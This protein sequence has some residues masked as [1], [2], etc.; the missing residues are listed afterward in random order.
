MSDDDSKVKSESVE[1]TTNKLDELDYEEELDTD[2]KYAQ[3]ANSNTKPQAAEGESDD[4]AVTDSDG[5]VKSEKNNDDDDDDGE[6]KS[7][8]DGDSEFKEQQEPA[9]PETEEDG[10]I[11]DGEKTKKA[12]IPR[13]L[14]KYYQRGKCTWGRTCKFLHPGVNDT[15]NYS[16]LEFQDPNAKVYQQQSNPTEAVDKPAEVS[17]ENGQEAVVTESAWERG[18]RHA[19]EMKE[20]AKLRKLA[21]KDQFDDKKMNLSLKEFENEKENDERYFSVVQVSNA[22]DEEDEDL[23]LFAQ[24]SRSGKSSNRVQQPTR[25]AGGGS[26][27]RGY[28][29][30]SRR[31]STSDY[32]KARQQTN[33]YGRGG[34][35]ARREVSSP[36]RGA[37]RGKAD[38]WHD[39][40]DRSRQSRREAASRRERSRSYSSSESGSRSPGRSGSRSSYS[41]SSSKS[42]SSKSS[43][44]SRSG[45]RSPS[46]RRKSGGGQRGDKKPN[47][48]Q[49]SNDLKKKIESLKS[50]VGGKSLPGR[51]ISDISLKKAGLDT[52]KSNKKNKKTRSR[53]RSN[54]SM[55]SYGSSE[56]V[57]D[58]EDMSEDSDSYSDDNEKTGK[59]NSPANKKSLKQGSKGG[60][61]RPANDS[62]LG[63]DSKKSKTGAASGD[64]K[65]MI[66][67]QLK[68]LE[69][70]LKKKSMAK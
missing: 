2:S 52:D 30:D 31:Q 34:G 49:L 41:S 3:S 1:D 47:P 40:W 10:E 20:K 59:K 53:S 35:G 56:S 23:H 17:G 4:G 28:D 19:R 42:Y 66:K 64:K 58:D 43:D 54:S 37:G 27:G 26:S 46:A 13:V 70:A 29:E 44:S 38:D 57:S 50:K 55:S 69:S 11:N 33:D 45:S 36:S 25:D 14:C 32:S 61:K 22:D 21:E 63:S 51:Q 67:D 65:Q 16:F 8:R 18:L 48:K 12:F 68:L 6:V 5:E 7:P 9:T 60:L 39:P 15:G 24:S 62:K